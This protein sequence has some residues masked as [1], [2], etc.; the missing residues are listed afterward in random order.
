MG[1]LPRNR[2]SVEEDQLS[3][4][5]LNLIDSLLVNPSIC[6]HPIFVKEVRH[7]LTVAA[8]QPGVYLTATS[9]QKLMISISLVHS[10]Y[11][12]LNPEDLS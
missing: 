12:Q 11:I 6:A 4:K 10:C 8:C 1:A 5:A 3:K 2:F 7:A 9:L